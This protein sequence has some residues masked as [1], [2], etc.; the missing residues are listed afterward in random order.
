[1]ISLKLGQFLANPNG[2]FAP[3]PNWSGHLW[4]FFLKFQ[5]KKQFRIRPVSINRPDQCP[6]NSAI[7]FGLGGIAGILEA[8]NC[9][10]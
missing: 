4:F 10:L 7:P 6:L 8:A 1:M 2:Q 9:Q 3:W 5:L